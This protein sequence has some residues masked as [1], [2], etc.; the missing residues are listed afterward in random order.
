MSTFELYIHG[1]PYG[2]QIWGSERN[3]DYI[4]TF[5]NHD[6]NITDKA[7]LQID[8]C[9][10]DSYYTYIHQQDVYDSDERPGAFFAMT[11]C[12]PKSYCTNV[13]KLYQIFE[14]VYEQVCVG[15]LITQKPNKEVFL[16]SDLE[17]S[18]SGNSATVDKIR[19]IFVK[20]IADLI[21][22]FIAP[23]ANIPDTFSKGKKQFSLVEVDSPLFFDFFKKQSIVVLPNLEPSA[24]ANQIIAKQLNS[25]LAQK[26]TLETANIQLQMDNTQLSRENKELSRQLHVSAA[27]SEKKYSSTINQL[28][29]ELRIATQ[30]RDELKAKIEDAKSSIELIDEPMQKLTRLLAGRFPESSKEHFKDSMERLHASSKKNTN[31]VWKSGLNSILLG[32]VIVLCIAILYFVAFG[33]DKT[34]SKSYDIKTEEVTDSIPD[35]YYVVENE[36]LEI[37]SDSSEVK[38][39]LSVRTNQY[40]DWESCLINIV[41]GGD[42]IENNKKYT[43][44]VQKKN[45]TNANV[46]LGSWSVWIKPNESINEG[47]SFALPEGT[48]P[49]TNV[50]INYIV[51]GKI[52]LSR[53]SK[54]IK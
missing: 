52:V 38:G 54:V 26:K 53:T 27:S 13:S 4:N 12:F 17:S 41:G 9:M 31:E 48:L 24:I 35:T 11:V 45:Y 42:K 6:S 40:D 15:T 8:I 25:A 16:V 29:S 3:H 43:L 28:K 39:A 20:N 18:R 50:M 14:A 37:D 22:P 5:Y 30:E 51:D 7:A 33:S 1:T 49:E 36:S 44:K 32:T 47:D 19:A 2:H 10:G 34:K 46:P 21:Q 23:L